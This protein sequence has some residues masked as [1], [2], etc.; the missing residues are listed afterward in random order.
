VLRAAT[1]RFLDVG[2]AATT[3]RAVASAS[4]VSVPT[5]E[6]LFRT[7]PQLLK[8]A[9]DVAIAGDDA[10][11][12]MLEREWAASAQEAADPTTFLAIF[13]HALKDAAK[14]SAGLIAAAHEAAASD[15]TIA[16]LT[17]QLSEQRLVTVAWIVDEVRHRHSL[18]PGLTRKRGIDTMWLLMDPIVY[19][20]LTRD[21]TWTPRQFERW[22]TETA[23]LLLLGPDA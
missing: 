6:L 20:R 14:R 11:T 3:I 23:L 1:D 19:L 21:R 2:Y 4:G 10:P 16:E 15:P 22:F 18:R 13:A 9:I 5:V 7:K 12:P 17:R 8:E